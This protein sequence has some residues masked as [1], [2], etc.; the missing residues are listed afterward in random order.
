MLE[1]PEAAASVG[2]P[3]AESGLLGN[4]ADSWQWRDSEVLRLQ[5][6]LAERSL[7]IAD[8]GQ[9][10]GSNITSSFLEEL[11]SGTVGLDAI[12][13]IFDELS[14]NE[15]VAGLDSAEALR[16]VIERGKQ[17]RGLDRLKHAVWD[18]HTSRAEL[19]AIIRAESWI[20]GGR[21]ARTPGTDRLSVLDQIG[22][23]LV[24]SDGAIHVVEVERA[25]VTDLVYRDGDNYAVGPVVHA[26]VSRAIN[27]LRLLDRNE[28]EI[29]E[30][31]AVESRRA[32][33][34]VVVGHPGFL[35]DRGAAVD[36]E[37]Q[38]ALRTYASHLAG[39][40]VITYQDLL[41]G[42]DRALLLSDSAGPP[43]H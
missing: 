2:S 16:A 32:M 29:R 5:S 33:A 10:D 25:N 40:D 36:S 23:P 21:Y 26:A 43:R 19:A 39:I 8:P 37:V 15:S 35:L 13:Q 27:Q 18:R 38:N 4:S 9:D 30:Q 3:P 34:T 1:L 11:R 22:I 12:S 14:G 41:E 42:A 28:R 17:R 20:F 6:L 7:P 31:V 24:R